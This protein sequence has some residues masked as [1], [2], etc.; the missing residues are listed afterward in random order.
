MEVLEILKIPGLIFLGLFVL[1][2]LVNMKTSRPDGTLIKNLH[3]YR[4]IMFYIMPTRNESVVYFEEWV[5]VQPIID[6]LEK[7]KTKFDVDFTHVIVAA[8]A[9]GF[10]ENPALNRFVAGYRLYQRNDVVLSFA[11]KR[12]KK[13]KT[14]KLST[15]KQ[16]LTPGITFQEF[17]EAINSKI[18][19]ERSGK[20]T[21]ADKEF[22]LFNRIPRPFYFRAQRL[23]RQLDY[24]NILPG[25]FIEN[26]PMYTS[27][28]VANL[29]SIDLGAGFHH[30]YEWGSCPLFMMV[31]K[32][33]ER[34]VVENGEV[35]VKSMIPIR[36]TF[37]ERI[38]DGL[39]A[40]YGIQSFKEILESPE[41]ALGCLNENKSDHFD[42]SIPRT[43]RKN[44]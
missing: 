7:A 12:I 8:C 34:A 32:I 23:F 9:L 1:W 15:V 4:K 18:T 31:G 42:L 13:D 26:D 11:M 28:F 16:V 22:D 29:G 33:E 41:Q 24:W 20:K 2:V 35:V 30:L 38:D 39:T 43:E 6:Y 25:S 10:V 21:Y 44:T 17:C 37:D 19:V 5:E 27:I 36:F 3:P 40:S 14:A